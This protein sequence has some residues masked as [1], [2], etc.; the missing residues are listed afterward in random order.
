MTI[1]NLGRKQRELVWQEV[2]IPRPY[3]LQTLLDILGSLAALTFRGPIVWEVRAEKG[4]LHYYLATAGWSKA[5]VMSA[6]SAHVNAQFTPAI[7]PE[8]IVEVRRLKITNN[9]LPLKTGK[10]VVAAMVRT[11]IL[12]MTNG[13]NKNDAVLQIILGRSHSPHN[14]PQNMGD[15]TIS[16]SRAILIGI[17]TATKEQQRI[18]REKAA[19]NSFEVVI[20]FGVGE[21]ETG[22]EEGEPVSNNA[23]NVSAVKP[24]GRYV[25]KLG[26]MLSSLK[27]I[28]GPGVY[29]S[30]TKEKPEAINQATLPWRMPLRLSISELAGF[31]LLPTGQEEVPGVTSIHPKRILPPAWYREPA[32]PKDGKVNKY[33][34]TFALSLEHWPKKLSISPKDALEH[35]IIAGPTGSGKSTAMLSLILAD[36]NA[37]RSVLVIDPKSDMIT[38]ILE[39]LPEERIGDVVVIDPSDEAPVG[40]NPLALSDSTSSPSVIS[41]AILAVFEEL[42]SNNWGIRTQDVLGA[43]LN[44]LAR[45]PGANLLWLIPLLTN[46]EFRNGIVAK[47]HDPIG[48]G[49][50]WE[51]F[52]AMSPRERNQEIGPVLVYALRWLCSLALWL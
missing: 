27:N 40:F 25:T 36:I 44:T 35:S 42:F 18:A 1:I 46:Q 6:I 24:S 21:V 12:S 13:S 37:G 49:V 31:L 29:I 20:R 15:P 2:L 5:R 7:H 50:F 16:L 17:P 32:E 45:T 52:E 51:H 34:R 11:T 22:Y 41:D 30:A 28:E 23:S 33:D 14:L 4:R 39:R 26:N 8:N 43:A 38:N 48:L 9:I 3:E 10:E 47:V 19:E